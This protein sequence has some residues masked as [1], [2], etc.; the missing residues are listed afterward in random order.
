MNVGELT[1]SS[2]PDEERPR[3][4]SN[5]VRKFRVLS[6]AIIGR[7]INT[8]VFFF[9]AKLSTVRACLRQSVRS[10]SA[11]VGSLIQMNSNSKLSGVAAATVLRMGRIARL[12][13]KEI[14]YTIYPK[15]KYL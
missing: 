13:C 7:N 15:F 10:N 11:L 8:L 3:R 2:R 14:I 6:L 4:K 1:Y 5:L 9:T 12:M